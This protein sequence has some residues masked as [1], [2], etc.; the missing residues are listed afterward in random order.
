VRFAVGALQIHPNGDE[1]SMECQ[2]RFPRRGQ[3]PVRSPSSSSWVFSYCGH[4]EKYI[5]VMVA[6]MA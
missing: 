5:R 3:S 4:G 2:T 1:F 6:E